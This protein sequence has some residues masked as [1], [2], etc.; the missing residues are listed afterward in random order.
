MTEPERVAHLLYDDTDRSLAG[1]LVA[2]YED[3]EPVD[4]PKEDLW[5]LKELE[6]AK[7]VEAGEI[8]KLGRRVALK[9]QGM[10]VGG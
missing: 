3:E 1:L 4:V 8:T 5:M 6:A 10:G 9:L 7:C 2:M